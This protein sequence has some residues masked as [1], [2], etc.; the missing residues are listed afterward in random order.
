MCSSANTITPSPINSN[1]LHPEL[2]AKSIIIGAGQPIPVPGQRPLLVVGDN[3]QNVLNQVKINAN[4]MQSK[5]I[6]NEAMPVSANP[7]PNSAP[8]EQQSARSTTG[9]S[10][11]TSVEEFCPD[12]GALDR[13]F[14]D[15]LP[16]SANTIETRQSEFNYD[17]DSDGNDTGN[18]LVAK[19]HDDPF[20]DVSIAR[21]PVKAHTQIAPKSEPRVNPL[22]KNKNKGIIPHDLSLVLPSKRRSSNSSDDNEIPHILTAKVNDHSDEFDSW[23]S[24]TNQRRSPEGGEDETSLPSIDKSSTHDSNVVADIS[25]F[26]RLELNDADDDDGDKHTKEKSSKI[27]KKKKDKKEKKDK[28]DKSDKEKK[29]SKS[30]KSTTEHLLAESKES[31]T[32]SDRIAT[33]DDQYEAL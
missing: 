19:F 17:S 9:D 30:K 23:L 14:L 18:P 24:D 4:I 3:K 33:D 13:G 21:N 11:V 31:S 15:D 1:Q 16:S 6:N 29:R 28:I 20:D 7:M 27:K 25:Q 22:A 5:S 26:D 8:A 12:G 10:N 2:R 32:H